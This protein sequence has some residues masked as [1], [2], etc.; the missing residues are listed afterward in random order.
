MTG[1]DRATLASPSGDAV[2][3]RFVIAALP[4]PLER[5]RRSVDASN[6]ASFARRRSKGATTSA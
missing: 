2:V 3:Q 4:D 1:D 5:S 6:L